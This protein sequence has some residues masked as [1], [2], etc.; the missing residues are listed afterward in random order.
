MKTLMSVSAVIITVLVCVNHDTAAQQSAPEINYICSEYISP[1]TVKLLG[2]VNTRGNSIECWFELYSFT[3]GRSRSETDYFGPDSAGVMTEAIMALIPVD[4]A[5][6]YWLM[7]RYG[8]DT[9]VSQVNKVT[10]GSAADSPIVY[11]FKVDDITASSYRSRV[12]IRTQGYNC[13]ARFGVAVEPHEFYEWKNFAIKGSPNDTVIHAGFDGLIPYADHRTYWSVSNDTF[14]R[15]VSQTN[16]KPV[17]TLFDSNALGMATPVQIT[18][19]GMATGCY[20]N[21]G[22]NTHAHYCYD[23]ALGELKLPPPAPGFDVRL[24]DTRTG[25]G[26][27]LI[28]G[29]YIDIRPFFFEAQV[30]T[31]KISLR[32]NENY[33]PIQIM[34]QDLSDKYSGPVTLTTLEDT[35]DMLST[36]QYL[37]SN[38]E[39]AVVRIFAAGPKPRSFQPSLMSVKP[40]IGSATAAAIIGEVNPNGASAMAWFEWGFTSQYGL[41]GTVVPLPVSF[42]AIQVSE[43]LNGL[44][45]EIRYHY[46]VVAQTDSGI[47]YGMDQSFQTSSELGVVDENR[48]PGYLRLSQNYPNP[49]NPATTIEYD[50]PSESRVRMRIYNT[51]GQLLATVV[52]AVQQAGPKSVVWNAAGNPSGLYFCRLE[53]SGTNDPSIV[54]TRSKKIVLIK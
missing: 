14:T 30:D 41:S 8:A 4:D 35:V 17:Q 43:M 51:A 24:A 44:S 40:W 25:S 10:G 9:I 52:D 3:S 1:G 2:S 26:K 46:R 29:T 54:L 7:V 15:L 12:T 22:V 33:Y 49:F 42:M 21:F 48:D 32:A 31:Y 47:Y 11:D 27:C 6:S 39:I 20:L 13:T 38:P 16:F 36:T 19:P 18:S 5:I 34:W 37:I 50:L 28:D 53:A 45:P 23:V